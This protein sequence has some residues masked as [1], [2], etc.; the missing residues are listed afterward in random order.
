MN[1]VERLI[2]TADRERHERHE[3]ARRLLARRLFDSPRPS[4]KP[5]LTREEYECYQQRAREG[6]PHC[7]VWVGWMAY[8]GHGTQK[9]ENLGLDWLR[10]AAAAGSAAGA[11]YCG[12]HALKAKNYEEALRFFHQAAEKDY[13][14]GLLWLGLVH[15]RGYGIP[16][17]KGKGIGYL[18][19]AARAG[20]FFARRELALMMIRGKL[21]V[22]N[23]FAGLVLLL[24]SVVAALLDGISNGYS[25]RFMG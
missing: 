9:D 22:A 10:K 18:K 19:R 11:F 16:L 14:P 8:T 1:E 6:D 23:I 21:G 5:S 3:R 7:Q 15:V 12:R 13:S 4:F 17:D 24:Y 25:E 2:T 20:N